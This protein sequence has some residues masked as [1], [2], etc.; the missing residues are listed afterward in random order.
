M[1]VKCLL[2]LHS[3]LSCWQTVVVTK[4]RSAR[5]CEKGVDGREKSCGAT[6]LSAHWNKNEKKN[7]L[8]L[9][10]V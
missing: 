8:D 9:G 5:R 10:S 4:K 1:S 2:S 3:K 7:Q 6:Q